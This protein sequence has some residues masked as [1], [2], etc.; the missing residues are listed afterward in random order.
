MLVSLYD[1]I[2]CD[3]IN[4]KNFRE[5]LSY[6]FWIL[7]TPLISMKILFVE[8]YKT[9]N[10]LIYN[11]WGWSEKGIS[12]MLKF[13]SWSRSHL[14]KKVLKFLV[15]KYGTTFHV[16]VGHFKISKFLKIWLKL[17]WKFVQIFSLWQ[18]IYFYFS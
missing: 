13:P 14:R 16:A 10:K 17:E 8:I 3:I 2:S 5:I 7:A 4:V 15:Q 12:W 18:V 6:S 11:W 9:V 1:V